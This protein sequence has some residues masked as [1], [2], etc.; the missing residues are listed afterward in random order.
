[1]YQVT[2]LGLTLLSWLAAQD[3]APPTPESTPAKEHAMSELFG[4]QAA[5]PAWRIIDDGVMGGRS[6]GT[7]RVD[8]GVGLFSGD[9]SLENN[10]GFSSVRSPALS[11]APSGATGFRLRVKGDG[12][13]YQ[14][15]VRTDANFDGASYRVEFSTRAGEWQEIELAL[16]DFDA[17]F[18][19]TVLRDYPPLT[20]DQVV[21]L[22]FLLADKKPGPFQLEVDWIGV[23]R[24]GD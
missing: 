13:T 5:T 21:T 22:G 3:V 24:P 16:A 9:L 19:G 17:V 18:R 11:Q 8:A 20:G 1:M 2:L 14:F 12:R 6:R 23:V 15:R 4:F 7:W 10:G